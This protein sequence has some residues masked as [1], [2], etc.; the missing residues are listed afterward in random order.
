MNFIGFLCAFIILIWGEVSSHAADIADLAKQAILVEAE[1]GTV[2]YE[3]NADELMVPSSM[4]KLMTVIPVFERLKDGRLRMTDQF[5]VSVNAWKKEGSRMFINPNTTVSVEDLLKGI[6]IQSGNDACTA[7]AE[8]LGGTESNYAEEMTR[9]AHKIGATNSTFKNAS[10]LPEPDH[11]TTPRDLAT[12]ARTILKK[13]PEFY[14]LFGEKEFT[15]NNIKQ[16]NRNP[17]LYKPDLQ[18]D[19]FKTGHTEAAGYGLVGSAIQN[20]MRL[21][22]VINGTKNVNERSQVSENLLRWGFREFRKFKLFSAGKVL[23]TAHVWMGQEPTVPLVIPQDVILFML[24]TTRTTLT[25]QL[26][27]TNPLVAPLKAGTVVGKLTV[28]GPN[29]KTIDYPVVVG[30][31]VEEVGPVERITS[32]LNYVIWGSSK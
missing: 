23:E 26:T 21:I 25:A 2:L 30:K 7:L 20:G 27:Y 28:S 6:I 31:T 15:Y 11:L 17:L 13:Y 4:S 3:K 18:A 10:G 5:P 9:E 1:T 24:G 16:G 8:G 14:P 22:V 32:A 19:G 12:I 29:F